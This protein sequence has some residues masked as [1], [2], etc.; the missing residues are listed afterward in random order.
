MPLR[1]AKFIPH[2]KTRHA[3][4]SVE[5]TRHGSCRRR[6][7]GFGQWLAVAVF[8]CLLLCG[9]TR[10]LCLEPS[11][12]ITQYG[13]TAWRPG[14]DGLESLPL[15]IAQTTDGYI[16]V[17]TAEGLLRF[18]GVRFTRWTAPA[19]EGLRNSKIQSLLGARDGS[20]YIATDLGVAR[21][22]QGHLYNYPEPLRWTGHLIEDRLGAIWVGTQSDPKADTVCKVGLN[23]ISCRGM[24]DGLGC[25]YG[26]S[27][28]SDA[29]GSIWIGSVE[30][31]CRWREN[32]RPENFPL[33][34]LKPGEHVRAL[35]FDSRGSAWAGVYGTAPE[36][37]LL[38][39][40]QGMWKRDSADVPHED[41]FSVTYLLSDRQ[42]NLWIGTEKKGIYRLHEGVLDHYGLAD[43]LSDDGISQVFE[44]REGGLWVI[45]KRGIDFFH[46]LPV[47]TF[48]SREGL[49][50][51]MPFSI[52]GSRDGD[53]WVGTRG[54]LDHLHDGHF[55]HVRLGGLSS[56]LVY[57][58]ID[59][60]GQLWLDEDKLRLYH[61][62]R[63]STVTDQD[64][65]EVGTVAEIM[66][67]NHH[68][69]WAASVNPMK[70]DN[71]LI[72]IQ[73]LRVTEKYVLPGGQY[74]NA[75]ARNPRGGFWAVGFDHGLFWF[76]DRRFERI[77][78]D[79]F[80]GPITDLRAE[81]DGGL[82]FTAQ[83]GSYLYKNGVT[84]RLSTQNG[85]PCDAS[86]FILDGKDGSHW[87]YL[88]CGI[89]RVRDSELALWWKDPSYKIQSTFFGAP[90]GAQVKVG[91][92]RPWIGPD[93]RQWS[94]NGRAVQMIDPRHL[95]FNRLPPPVHVERMLVNHREQPQINNLRL[96]VSPRDI[97]IDYVGLSYLVPDKV[98][99][100][101]QLVGHDRG[102]IDAGARRQVFYNDLRPGTYTFRVIA[103]NNDG[104]W[105]TQG[106]ALQFTIPPAWFQTPW[107]RLLCLLLAVVAGLTIYY[108]IRLRRYAASMRIRF[109]ERLEE[110][111]RLA[112][113]LHDTLMQTV[114][115]I[116]LVA[117]TARDTIE[118]PA[119]A[120]KFATLIAEW[121]GR[122]TVEG[123][124][125]LDSLRNSTTEGND[126][127][128]A[129]RQSFEECHAKGAITV[130]LSVTGRSRQMH[131]IVRD[132]IYRIGHEAIRNACL[133]S[134][135]RR[136]DIE[137]IYH[138]NMHLCIRDDGKGIDT[139]TLKSGREGHYGLTGMRERAARIG[140]RLDLVSSTKGTEIHLRVP[141]KGIYTASSTWLARLV[142]GP[143][144]SRGTD[145]E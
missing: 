62:N 131:P 31:I 107:F 68:E 1:A 67:D 118:D 119:S 142:K 72:H 8:S 73:G 4:L 24:D 144:W 9:G 100:Q 49:S 145:K 83:Q 115:G 130:N 122:A 43:G 6:S 135:G 121:S 18:D 96:P 110:R 51:D 88:D 59:S 64:N 33:A 97:E 12:R 14:H 38:R 41:N 29:P 108:L 19:G 63:L 39:F 102:W 134:G 26:L 36:G 120:K 60:N 47:I 109:D 55:S 7:V 91:G 106:D 123:R 16:W 27:L 137:L 35:A 112:R 75:L 10:V 92:Q 117:D 125:A 113:D 25:K 143:G 79:G 103:S 87:F 46:D 23:H 82:W 76:H 65:S 3:Q 124:E 28:A 53:L 54:F 71:G 101:Y 116:R 48:T 44:D 80:D 93:G 90:D 133:H 105:N 17:G 127:A 111:T 94:V 5:A 45:T 66:E 52:T 139:T 11:T 95:R 34:F 21:L 13:H 20:L 98:R 138:E 50:L 70:Q 40:S 81:P 128:R 136:V 77:K 129:F 2:K 86:A 37:G 69:V 99:F 61:D 89:V 42:N 132:E 84:R 58:F 32:A 22:T 56:L 78:L 57:L 141:G 140:A 85:L 114:Q 74:I 15:T 126:L 30:G 104:V